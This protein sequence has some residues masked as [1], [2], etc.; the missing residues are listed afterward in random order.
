MCAH[1]ASNATL[2]YGNH[3]VCCASCQRILLTV[4][5]PHALAVL[6][7]RLLLVTVGC[8]FVVTVGCG[9]VYMLWPALPTAAGLQPPV[10]G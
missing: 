3:I 9:F 8:G 1:T 4:L 5:V 6:E 10:I 7:Y 2:L